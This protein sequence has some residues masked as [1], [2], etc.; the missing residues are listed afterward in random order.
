MKLGNFE[1]LFPVCQWLLLVST[2]CPTNESAQICVDLFLHGAN[3]AEI[4]VEIYS[5]VNA[6]DRGEGPVTRHPQTSSQAMKAVQEYAT[7]SKEL[8]ETIAAELVLLLNLCI[9][10]LVQLDKYP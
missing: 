7:Q 9:T 10:G 3:F 2:E 1:N 5:P 4:L 8:Q 6:D